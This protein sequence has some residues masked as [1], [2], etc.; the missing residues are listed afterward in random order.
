[1][2]IHRKFAKAYLLCDKA[3]LRN[4]ADFNPRPGVEGTD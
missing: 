1:M 4:S 2:E 3:S